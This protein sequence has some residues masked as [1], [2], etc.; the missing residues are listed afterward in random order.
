[1]PILVTDEVA[2]TRRNLRDIRDIDYK[3][4][5]PGNLKLKPG[6][7]SHDKLLQRL[8]EMAIASRNVISQRFESWNKLDRT[9]TAYVPLSDAEQNLKNTDARRPLS[10]VV[11]VSY[12]VRETLLTYMVAAFLEHPIYRYE[13]VGP[14]DVVGAMLLEHVVDQQARKFKHG[15]ALHT[16]WADAYT[17]GFGLATPLWAQKTG[18]RKGGKKR[19]P[20]IDPFTL[21]VENTMIDS[22]QPEAR[23]SILCEGNDLQNIDPYM[24]LPDPN[25]PI[26]RLQ[27]GEFFGWVDRSNRY[28]ILTD[29]LLSEGAIFNARYLEHIGDGRSILF[30]EEDARNEKEGISTEGIRGIT[31]TIDKITLFVDLIPNEWE[32]GSYKYPEKWVFTI[33]SDSVIL[34]AQ[35]LELEHNMFP[36]VVCAPDTDGYSATPQSRLEIIYPMQHTMD[37]LYSTRIANVRKALNDM[38]VYDPMW[39]NPNDMENPEPGKLIR[40]RPPVW[41]RGVKDAIMQFPVSD[42]T[43]SHITD[44]NFLEE[45]I[46]RVSGASNSMQGILQNS[47]E[48]I[49]ATHSRNAQMGA[50]TRIE[51][52]T[53]LVGIM[54][55]SD[56][57]YMLAAQTQQYMSQETYVK[58]AGRHSMD[59]QMLAG[60]GQFLPVSPLDL[61]ISYDVQASSGSLPNSVDPQFWNGLLQV[62]MQDPELRQQMDIFK[63]FTYSAKLAGAKNVFDF[64]RNTAG[65]N[66]MQMPMQQVEQQQQAGNIVPLQE[67]ASA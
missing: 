30:T 62:A 13:P 16:Q 48:R 52:S 56:L 46:Q 42:V 19:L 47:S 34:Q 38:F 23:P 35:P 51:K 7:E 50:L 24:S 44:S 10:I 6:S 1:M 15:L 4:S 9:L 22:G 37:W 61:D 64:V 2:R 3:Y 5:Y 33:A 11:P 45:Q 12:A 25:V 66:P 29:E 67:Y 14:E 60:G 27:D 26:H 54:T 39:I 40:T 31:N 49:S 17:Y 59:L 18:L 55:M 63:L 43:Q 57:A 28:S 32:L 21:Q 53:I 36:V 58:I 20:T 65:I 41:G 8:M